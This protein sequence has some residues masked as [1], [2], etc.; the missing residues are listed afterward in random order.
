[1]RNLID[2]IVE[3]LR[4]MVANNPREAGWLISTYPEEIQ[5]ELAE[6]LGYAP[7]MTPHGRGWR[8][9]DPRVTRRPGVAVAILSADGDSIVLEQRWENGLWGLPS[10]ALKPGESFAS[11]A[12]RETLEE[13]GLTVKLGRMVAVYSDPAVFEYVYPDGEQSQS[14]GVVFSATETGGSI[15]VSNESL[16]VRRFHRDEVAD[17]SLLPVQ[18]PL[19]NLA[20]QGPAAWGIVL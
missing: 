12:L 20:L 1:M 2:R 13:T 6:K 8:K 10:G 3:G 18:A 9:Y 4:P 19:I 14:V 16:D 11:A 17:L 7:G 5:P 15:T